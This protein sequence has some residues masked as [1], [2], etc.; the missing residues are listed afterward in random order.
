MDAPG[1]ELD[2]ER[3]PPKPT[4]T[5]RERNYLLTGE[6]E[7]Y[8]EPKLNRDV[9]D[10]ANML[11]K[12]IQD[13]ID[14]ISLLYL[15]DYLEDSEGGHVFNVS[16]LEFRTQLVRDQT[17]VQ[18]G[19]ESTEP[20]SEFAFEVGCLF[21]M[22]EV[23]SAPADIVWGFLIGLAGHSEDRFAEERET[24]ENILHQLETRHEERLFHA[25]TELVLGDEDGF[26]ELREMTHDILQK[27]GVTPVSVLVD[28]VVQYHINPTSAPL[29]L[30]TD[31]YTGDAGQGNP[32]EQP[33]GGMS[34]REWD[35]MDVRSLIQTL[36]AETR[37]RDVEALCV[38]LHSD[39]REVNERMQ[40]GTRAR[41]LFRNMP[42]HGS[43]DSFPPSTYSS[44]GMRTAV[45]HRLSG[46]E[47]KPLWTTRPVVEESGDDQWKLT[48]YG[49]LLYRTTFDNDGSTSWIYH[50]LLSENPLSEEDESLIGDV[51]GEWDS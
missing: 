8:G 32:P 25:G 19:Q 31:S 9:T 40:F 17:V 38:D 22:L 44:Q 20:A 48:P 10:K 29:D 27:E 39:V 34:V 14:D 50:V 42:L 30:N 28:A 1:W 41:D 5:G 6:T 46:Q 4:L 51:L 11:T 24:I 33:S 49:R 2:S 15:G 12:R 7:P 3:N 47:E 45:L 43:T 35:K 13:L 37:L 18:T 21:S 16:D 23:D 36:L 26:S